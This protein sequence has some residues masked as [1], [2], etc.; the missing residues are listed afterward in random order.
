M[1]HR[2]LFERTD[3]VQLRFAAY[4]IAAIHNRKTTLF[5]HRQERNVFE[6]PMVTEEEL[7]S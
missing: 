6:T 4:L 2:D 7:Y 1:P 3:P 5:Q